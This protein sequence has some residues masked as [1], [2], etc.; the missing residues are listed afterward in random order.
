MKIPIFEVVARL[1]K[2][3]V[4]TSPAR[5]AV[6][7]RLFK[8]D[9]ATKFAKFA[10]ETRPRRFCVLTRPTILETLI[11]VPLITPAVTCSVLSEVAIISPVVRYPA[12]DPILNESTTREE[13]YPLEDLRVEVTIEET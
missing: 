11:E 7:T 10:V 9:A 2:L 12:F 1:D 3:A 5:L 6:E 13:I 4:E 8:L